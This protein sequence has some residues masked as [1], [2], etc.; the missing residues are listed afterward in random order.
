MW[1]YCLYLFLSLGFFFLLNVCISEIK[2]TIRDL[3][4]TEWNRLRIPVYLGLLFV[5]HISKCSSKRRARRID[6]AIIVPVFSFEI[7]TEILI[8]SLYWSNFR[9]FCLRYR[10]Y[11]D[12]GS[13]IASYLLFAIIAFIH[14]S[15]EFFQNYVRM[16][17][18]WFNLKCTH[19]VCRRTKSSKK[20]NITQ[21]KVRGAIDTSIRFIIAIYSFIFSMI[22]FSS[23]AITDA[24]D[25]N[26]DH[27][28]I[29]TIS[30]NTAVFIF[31]MA[32]FIPVIFIPGCA[33]K[34][35]DQQQINMAEPLMRMYNADQ[36][37][38]ELLFCGSLVMASLLIF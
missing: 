23:F 38:F 9:M 6:T 37:L 20:S 11:E 33:G 15:A 26:K 34:I 17:S 3:H 22:L 12:E 31:E 28:W 1:I 19:N 7:I 21:W 8:S 27:Q 30:L 25:S 24:I 10:I 35:S 5:Y 36:R 14:L 2:R 32:M 29:A 16:T 4:E 13:R 18:G